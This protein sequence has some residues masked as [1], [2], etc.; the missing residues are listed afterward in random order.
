V[1]VRVGQEV[2]DGNT[3]CLFENPLVPKTFAAAPYWG[4]FKETPGRRLRE[5]HGTALPADSDVSD[6]WWPELKDWLDSDFLKL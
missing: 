6:I 2:I 4:P 5:E 1:W 3:D